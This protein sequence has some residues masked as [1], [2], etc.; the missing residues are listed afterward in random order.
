[1]PKGT[2]KDNINYVEN[3]K[4]MM[5]ISNSFKCSEKCPHYSMCYRTQFKDGCFIDEIAEY[6]TSPNFDGYVPIGILSL[7]IGETKQYITSVTSP[8]GLE[9]LEIVDY[10]KKHDGAKDKYY[11]L[12]LIS[13]Y[14]NDMFRTKRTGT[15]KSVAVPVIESIDLQKENERLSN[16]LKIAIERINELEYENESLIDELDVVRDSANKKIN[17][18][19]NMLNNKHA[20]PINQFDNQIQEGFDVKKYLLNIVE[21][22]YEIGKH[23]A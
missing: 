1:M 15:K 2:K 3:A 19:E 7:I 8:Q 5:D 11:S 13:K 22:A 23:T 20:E 9:K 10:V 6:I 17:E 12:D 4:F 16:E 18:L 14:G 21:G